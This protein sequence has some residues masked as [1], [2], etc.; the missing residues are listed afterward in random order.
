MTEPAQQALEPPAAAPTQAEEIRALFERANERHR[1]GDSDGA[2]ALY[3]QLIE[4]FPTVPDAYNNLAVILK[5]QKHLP[6]AIACLKRALVLAP[7]SGPLHSNLGN[8]LWMNLQYD[9]AMAAFRRALSID[10]TRPEVYPQSRPA[11][12]Q[13]RQLSGVGRMFRPGAGAERIEQAG[14]VGPVAGAAR[15]RRSGARLR[16]L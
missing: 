9:E 2:V 5:A 7:N 16:Q 3:V 6:A 13:P 4:R 11:L 15:R 14:A 12:F 10:P 1:A 8:M